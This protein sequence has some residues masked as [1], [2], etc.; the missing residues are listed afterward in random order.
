MLLTWKYDEKLNS[1]MYMQLADYI[2]MK[3][4]TGDLKDGTKL[5]GRNSLMTIFGVSKTTL[6]SAFDQLQREGLL[7][8]Y[9]K[10]GFFVTYN[11]EES[12]IDWKKYIEKAKHRTTIDE[13]RYWGESDGLVNFSL[14]SDF[15]MGHYLKD[16]MIN[17]SERV[18]NIDA[19]SE[20]SKY[21]LNSLRES[22][23]EHVKH[24]GIKTDIENILITSETIQRLYFVYETLLNSC[25]NFLY[26]DTNIINT[27]SNVHSLGMNMIPIKMDKNGMS[28]AEL[29]KKL[30]KSK[31]CPIIHIDPTDQ[32]PTGV[33]MSKKRRQEIINIIQKYR[34]PL[35]EVDHSANIWHDKPT[36]APLKS[37]D[38]NGNIIYLGSMLKIHPF[39]FQLSWIIADRYFIEHLSNVFIQNGVKPNFM[40]QLI[41]DEMIKNGKMYEM[42][43]DIKKFVN[44]R[45]EK[46]LR[47]CDKYFKS[48]GYW[49]EKNCSFHF[50][51]DFPEVNIKNIVARNKLEKTIYP[52]YFF[53]P[54]D[55]S[56]ILICPS[57]IKE[58]ALERSFAHISK[59]VDEAR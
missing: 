25:S 19:A 32:A 42:M 55:T 58:D 34:V 39:D 17:A 30:I 46:T 14:S 57:C 33:V 48:K 41:T 27:I 10:S 28:S 26:E 53:N 8:A 23:R 2:R 22:V 13:Y 50:W 12:K 6:L 7:Q 49:I 52:G 18:I 29:E 44:N 40:M 11:N 47:L 35:V 9:P 5:P 20:I 16:A 4:R 3:I 51:I 54:Q 38:K 45:R 31:F 43:G 56:H 59:L 15:E 37:M 24:F 21:G 36:L 1:P